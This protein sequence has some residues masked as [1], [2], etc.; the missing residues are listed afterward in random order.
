MFVS[1]VKENFKPGGPVYTEDIISLFPE[2]TKAYIFRLLKQA[3]EKGDIIKFSRGVYCLPKKTFFGKATMTSSMVANNKYVTNGETVYGVYSGL[4]LLN[5]FGITSQVP[6]VLEIV[7]NNEATRKRVVSIDGIKFIVRKSRFE[8]TK[9]NYRYYTIIQ[10][11]LD[12]GINPQLNDFAKRRII[13]YIKDNN[14]DPK[15]LI[16]LATRFPAQALKNLVESEVLNGI[17]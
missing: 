17:I 9:E 15:T 16:K 14:I 10:L 3:E 6:N 8:I 11:F 7:T 13:Q 1:R 5:Q 2:F 12:L 4:A